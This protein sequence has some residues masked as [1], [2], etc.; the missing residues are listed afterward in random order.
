MPESGRRADNAPWLQFYPAGVPHDVRI[1]DALLYSLLD[2]AARAYGGRTAL[3]FFGRRVSYGAL[4][5]AVDRFAAGL[6]DLGVSPGDRVALVLPNCPQ[7]VVTFFAALRIGAVAVPVGPQLSERELRHQLADSG[8]VAAVVVEGALPKVRPVLRHTALKH[9]ISTSLDE[10]LPIRLRLVL[11]LPLARSRAARRRFSPGVPRGL[12][13]IPWHE[14]ARHAPLG[15][16]AGEPAPARPDDMAVLQYTGGTTGAPK[17]VVLTHRNLLAN[18][19]QVEAWH[20]PLRGKRETTLAVLPFSHVYGL[21]LSLGAG[22]LNGARTVLLPAPDTGRLLRAARRWKPTLL[23]ATPP[24]FEDL[25]ARPPRELEALRTLR[26]C[27]SGALRL[28]PDAVSRFGEVGRARLV[29]SYGLTE[30]APV[31]LVNPLNANARPGTVGIPLPGTEI[32]ITR[33]DDPA[34]DAG[35][36]EAGELLVRGPQV[37]AGYWNDPRATAGRLR[38]GWLRTGD[39]AVMSPDGFVTLIDRSVDVIHMAGAQVFPSEIERVLCEH[40]AV[41]EAAVIGAPNPADRGLGQ[42]VRAVVVM[43]GGQAVS[44]SALIEHCAARLPAYKVPALMEFR[45]SSLPRGQVGKM[46]RRELRETPPA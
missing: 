15:E 45:G 27:V 46:L 1:P 30:A 14:V 19:H 22:I 41:R 4:R 13:T 39:I 40:P 34:T 43:E 17:G 26:G 24:V 12:D 20:A 23:H 9:V 25:L 28:S 18:A 3:V 2:D 38:D 35:P 31:V 37:F 36:G 7:F 8:A 29:E 11:R 6:R 5:R 10:A 32:R 42:V 16:A 21:T 44:R 33:E